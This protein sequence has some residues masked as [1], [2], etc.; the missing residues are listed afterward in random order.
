MQRQKAEL[1]FGNDKQ[2]KL[3]PLGRL[4]HSSQLR[5]TASQ[6][7]RDCIRVENHFQESKSI[8]ENSSSM[9]R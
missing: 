2:R 4:E 1:V 3:M 6:K 7:G 8:L 5:I 9:I